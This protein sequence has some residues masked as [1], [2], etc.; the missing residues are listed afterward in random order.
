MPI[1]RI[2]RLAPL[3]AIAALA[4][5]TVTAG[6]ALARHGSDDP[7]SHDVGDDHGGVRTGSDDAVT[8]DAGDDRGGARRTESHRGRGRHG[9]RGHRRAA[10]RRH[11]DDAP[12]HVRH[13][14]NDDGPNHT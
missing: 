6:P 13:S 4:A 1:H 14:G 9:R 2:H 3:A 10:Q 12:G 11:D 5:G 8:H 7:P